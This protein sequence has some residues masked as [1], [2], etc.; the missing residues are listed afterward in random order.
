MGGVPACGRGLD[1]DDLRS[2][3]TQ[4]T[5]NQAWGSGNP[6]FWE[7]PGNTELSRQ[8]SWG[9]PWRRGTEA[10]LEPIHPRLGHPASAGT[11]PRGNIP[12]EEPVPSA[13]SSSEGAG[14]PVELGSAGTS[15]THSW[16]S[17]GRSAAAPS[18]RN[19]GKEEAGKR[20]GLVGSRRRGKINQERSGVMQQ[21]G[22]GGWPR[23]GGLPAPT[24]APTL[25]CLE[26]SIGQE[27]S[28]FHSSRKSLGRG[29]GQTPGQPLRPGGLS[30]RTRGRWEQ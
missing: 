8:P 5:P 18:G 7:H 19:A 12:G 25:L 4:Q 6:K 27:P 9:C 13:A 30:G 22:E 24:S 28:N 1:L 20:G 21:P 15:R 2:L 10:A 3:P 26:G 11:A 17:T 14:I 16:D 29:M 23:S